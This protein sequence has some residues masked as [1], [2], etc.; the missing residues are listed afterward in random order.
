[1]SP[2]S[3]AQSD[4]TAWDLDAQCL[5]ARPPQTK[6]SGPSFSVSPR[7][8]SQHPWWLLRVTLFQVVYNESMLVA[9]DRA[10][11]EMSSRNLKAIIA[12]ANNWD[13]NGNMSDCK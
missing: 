11:A 1:M 13:Y 4:K 7:V 8:L 6:L 12:L 9:F 3:F 2:T 5:L 10:I